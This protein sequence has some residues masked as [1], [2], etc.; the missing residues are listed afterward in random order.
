MRHRLPLLNLIL[1]RGGPGVARNGRVTPRR[2]PAAPARRY[3]G[4]M[5]DLLHLITWYPLFGIPA[6]IGWTAVYVTGGK[7]FDLQVGDKALLLAPWLMLN[8]ASFAA[9][10]DK[11]LANLI[12]IV[13]IAGAVPLALLLRV[14]VGRRVADQ[15]RFAR[16]LVTGVS[17][18]AMLLWLLVP[19]LAQTAAGPLLR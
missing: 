2:R 4:A 18:L 3:N 7:N 6:G 19:N 5:N 1:E 9:P 16:Q 15:K 11:S 14:V 8:L 17:L 10:G 13:V 12:E